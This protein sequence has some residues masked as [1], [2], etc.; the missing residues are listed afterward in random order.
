MLHT[1]CSSSLSLDTA[2]FPARAPQTYVGPRSSAHSPRPALD[3]SHHAPARGSMMP[4]FIPL[5][6]WRQ[7]QGDLLMITQGV[8]GKGQN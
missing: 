6:G 2:A 3:S 8:S 5:Y 7:K 1:Q 4:L